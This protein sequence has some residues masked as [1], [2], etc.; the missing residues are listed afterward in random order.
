MTKL[1]KSLDNLLDTADF[2]T[3]RDNQC[4]LFH[5]YV[6]AQVFA[7]RE[8]AHSVVFWFDALV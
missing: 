3:G 7:K 4:Q 5:G 6:I 1:E 8:L 2:I